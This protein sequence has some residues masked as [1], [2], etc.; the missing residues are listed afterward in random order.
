MLPPEEYERAAREADYH[1]QIAI[2]QVEFESDD[3]IL[4]GTVVRVFRG[5]AAL[6][7]TIMR[8]NV[9]Y[10]SP[11]QDND[12]AP[13]GV[14]RLPVNAL[15]SGRTLEAFIVKTDTGLMISEGLCTLIDAATERPQL[16]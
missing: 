8:L 12:W 13:D 15:R 2:Q 3:A 14:G 6:H 9:S 4:Q 10:L 5:P 7:G 16:E 11:E 1:V